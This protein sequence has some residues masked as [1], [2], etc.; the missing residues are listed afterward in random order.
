MKYLI[1]ISLAA[2]LTVLSVFVFPVNG[3]E[4][5]YEKTIR[6]HVLANSDSDADQALKLKVRDEILV[7]VGS[8][9]GD[10]NTK[11]EAEQILLKERDNIKK[12]A[13]KVIAANGYDYDADVVLG[14]EYY[15]TREYDVV[16][17]PAGD[18]YSVRVQ[19]GKAEGKNWWCVLFP[20]LCTS[21]AKGTPES[22]MVAAGFTPNQ[23]RVLTDTE[24][25]RYLLK[26]KILEV[27][28]EFTHMFKN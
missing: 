12:A 4:G 27:F 9:I 24:N 3:E 1:A 11:Y 22:K 18:Y 20:Q 2:V 8:Y 13:E 16:M 23:V 28:N 15:P 7:E 19:I 21:S 26:F 17:L 6:L 10:C 25:P 14:V 5:I